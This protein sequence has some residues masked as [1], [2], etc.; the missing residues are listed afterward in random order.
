[1]N[2]IR[3]HLH[4]PC[5]PNV[6]LTPPI[7]FASQWIFLK[8]SLQILFLS[9]LQTSFC[10]DPWTA[11]TL[12]LTKLLIL[13]WTWF[14]WNSWHSGKHFLGL[15]LHLDVLKVDVVC[16]CQGLS[17]KTKVMVILFMADEE[18]SWKQMYRFP[19]S[20][21]RKTVKRERQPPQKGIQRAQE[22]WRKHLDSLS[23]QRCGQGPTEPQFP[24]CK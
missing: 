24:I 9:I 18:D 6:L 5:L 19:E 4:A 7:H 1:M 15:F 17:C 10:C 20:C 12:S 13:S 14:P 3:S 21:S 23:L 8:V 16:S 22:R 2:R 11:M